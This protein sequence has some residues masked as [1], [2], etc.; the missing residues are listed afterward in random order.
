M[1]PQ[2]RACKCIAN[3]VPGSSTSNRNRDR[4][5]HVLAAKSNP[6]RNHRP[7]HCTAAPLDCLASQ[8]LR[9]RNPNASSSNLFSLR[10]RRNRCPCQGCQG[11]NMQGQSPTPGYCG[12][13]PCLS[14]DRLWS[15]RLRTNAFRELKQ[16]QFGAAATPRPQGQRTL[17]G[18]GRRHGARA[19][20]RPS[21]PEGRRSWHE[22]ATEFA[23]CLCSLASKAVRGRN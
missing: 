14:D 18:A 23:P 15:H 5:G 2:T 1:T 16:I 4:P 13:P 21:A 8:P 20:P 3:H 17:P 10:N 6:L 9:L 19:S 22:L 12:R 7:C 11:W